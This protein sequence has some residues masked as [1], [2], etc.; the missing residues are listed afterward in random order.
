VPKAFWCPVDSVETVGKTCVEKRGRR[1]PPSE[2][3]QWKEVSV[4]VEVIISFF[5]L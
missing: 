3:R 4:C 1:C 2:N 5:T